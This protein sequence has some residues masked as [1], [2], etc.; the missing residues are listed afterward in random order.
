[1]Q[2]SIGAAAGQTVELALMVDSD[3]DLTIADPTGTVV[4][5]PQRV[6]RSYNTQ[7]RCPAGG[8]YVIKL[9]NSFSLITTKQVLVQY[10]LLAQSQPPR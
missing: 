2:L 10:R 9:D 4:Y 3:I 8:N 6:R 1:M 7:L 5:G